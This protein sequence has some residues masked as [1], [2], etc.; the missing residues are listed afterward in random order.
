[1][2]C[3]C[4]SPVARPE[5]VF[6][7]LFTVAFFILVRLACELCFHVKVRTRSVQP[8]HACRFCLRSLSALFE[9]FIRLVRQGGLFYEYASRFFVESSDFSRVVSGFF[10]STLTLGYLDPLQVGRLAHRIPSHLLCCPRAY[11]VCCA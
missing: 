8:T 1:M 2:L 5:H 9:I 11:L 4:S 7:G 3:G 6:F 10:T